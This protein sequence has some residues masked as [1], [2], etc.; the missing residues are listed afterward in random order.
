MTERPR[1]QDR[2]QEVRGHRPRRRPREPILVQI[3]AGRVRRS[4]RTRRNHTRALRCPLPLGL[5]A[6]AGRLESGRDQ[7]VDQGFLWDGEGE[8]AEE[9]S[10]SAWLTP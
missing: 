3:Y 8:V 10:G 7:A 1:L 4:D 6:E 2:R 5:S 9:D